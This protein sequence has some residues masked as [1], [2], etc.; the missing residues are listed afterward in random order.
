MFI[1]YLQTV[2]FKRSSSSHVLQVLR[3]SWW[4]AEDFIIVDGDAV[5]TG[6]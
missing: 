4:F 3:F 1:Y 5:S 2:I 6:R